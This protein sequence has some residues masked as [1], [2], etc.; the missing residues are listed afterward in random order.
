[1]AVK[2]GDTVKVEYTGTFDNG[3]MFDS[4]EDKGPLQFKVGG[5]EVIK[6]FDNAVVDM[7]VNQEKSITVEPKD[8]YGEPREELKHKVPKDKIPADV[9]PQVGQTLGLQDPQGRVF[10]IKIITVDADSITIDAN[11][12]LAGK[13]L[14]FKIKL[15][16]IL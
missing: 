6:G 14:H 4:S 15:L 2:Q 5:H 16:E 8:G 12:P 13:T 7:E 3:E 1:M 10:P 9:T 11:H